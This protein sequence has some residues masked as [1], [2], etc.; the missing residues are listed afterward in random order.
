MTVLKENPLLVAHQKSSSS[1]GSSGSGSGNAGDKDVVVLTDSNFDELVL[2]SDDLWLIDYYAPWCGHCKKLE[3]EWNKAATELKGEV[4]L[5][6]VDATVQTGLGSRFGVQGYPTIKMF[7]PGKKSDKSAED[8]SG[9]RDASS[10]TQFALDKKA[11]FK[12]APEV[13]QLLNT[14]TFEKLCDQ[15]KGKII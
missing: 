4:K 3:P 8:Y 2:K 10:I 15:T 6:K 14:E 5:G 13:V 9:G 12:P 11:Q 1:G 7:P